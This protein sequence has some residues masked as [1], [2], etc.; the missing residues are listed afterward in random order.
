MSTLRGTTR[1]GWLLLGLRVVQ[2]DK[3]RV[4]LY[5]R[6]V[7]CGAGYASIGE[8]PQVCPSCNQPT[9]W[10]SSPPHAQDW[11]AALVLTET[12]RRLLRSFKIDPEA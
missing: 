7:G 12:D 4:I 9:R 6:R 3:A 11:T 1:R 8:V 5:C 10:G 2:T